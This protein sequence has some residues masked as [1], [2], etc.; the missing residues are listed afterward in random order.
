MPDAFPP[1]SKKSALGRF[2]RTAKTA[3]VALTA[4]VFILSTFAESFAQRGGFG[5]GGM[6]G[7]SI[8]SRNPGGD[9]PRNP[10]GIGSG[11]PGRVIMIPPRGPYGGP[12]QVVVGD[13]EPAPRLRRRAKHSAKKQKQKQKTQQVADRGGFSV[14]PASERRFVANEVLLNMPAGISMLALDAIA[15]RHRLTRLDF[16]EFTLTRR[17]LARLRINDG[18]PVATVIRSLQTDAR[19]LGAQPNYLYTVQQGSAPQAATPDPA[20]YALAKLRLP[21]AHALATG[22][23]VLVAVI[24]TTVD[25][26]HPDLAG[27]VTAN[28]DATGAP[29]KPHA[30]GTG[31]AGV[32]AAH[33]KLTGAAPSVKVLAVHAFGSAGSDG[34]SMHILKGLEWAAKANANIVNMS[35]AGPADAELHT[36]LVALRGRG[37]I[38]IAAAGNAGP[39]ARPLYPAA[40]PETLAV[41][42][43]DIDDK[44]F[45]QANRG[46][47]IAVAA[48]GVDLLVAAPQGSYQMSSGTSFAAAQISGI[49]ALLLERNPKLD[50]ASIRRIL[51]S[52]ARDLGPVG[53]DEQFGS[54]LADAYAAVM[55]A[56]AKSS[57]ASGTPAAPAH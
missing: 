27:V 40:Y 52:T 20:Q 9:V 24:D 22:A 18:R 10:G 3:L 54:G 50:G 41:T 21:E 47:H 15:R 25:A 51:T 56:G 23:N 11:G 42:A 12:S 6:G 30:H 38:L 37:I 35:F 17:R 39:Q 46:T 49:A 14:P 28:F 26:S 45:A 53:H 57:D 19:I 7:G 31:I 43:T 36:M 2:H 16:Q 55:S 13:D 32:V 48:P 4:A 5:R 1:R 44:P 29:D 33:G 34:N 8:G